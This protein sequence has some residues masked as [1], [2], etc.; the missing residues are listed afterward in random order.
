MVEQRVSPDTTVRLPKETVR[1]AKRR[2]IEEDKTMKQLLTEIIDSYCLG[3]SNHS[4]N[5][6]GEVAAM[7]R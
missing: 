5:N 2:A 6:K 1:K 4:G 3:T 7:K